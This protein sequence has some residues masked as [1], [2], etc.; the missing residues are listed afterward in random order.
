MAEYHHEQVAY[1]NDQTVGLHAIIA[2]HSTVLGPSLGGCR[3]YHYA[4]EQDALADV[5]RLSHAMTYKAAAA[6]VAFGGGKSV[7][8]ADETTVKSEQIFRSFGRFVGSL[9]GRY[10]ASE[11]VGTSMADLE[12]AR[13]ETIHVARDYDCPD[14]DMNYLTA[15]GTY[16]GMRAAA[17]RVFGSPSLAGRTVAV[18]GLGHVGW[19]LCELLHAAGADLIVTDLRADI[20][21]RARAKW[22]ARAVAVDEILATPCD[23]LAPCAMGGVLDD[24]SIPGLACAIVAGSAN[25]V[26]AAPEHGRALHER[27]VLL[28][29]DYVINGGGLIAEACRLEGLD[30]AAARERVLRVYDNVAQ[31]LDLAD[32]EQIAPSDAADRFAEQR[33]A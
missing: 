17:T 28:A 20:C 19:P 3:M 5:L 13:R 1:W 8:L 29:P 7:I 15:L 27:G 21:D 24:A 12:W 22:G 30:F 4:C 18:Q 14:G 11:D 6:G 10:T 9:G 33:L 31:V 32:S 2:I 16:E 23:V 26:L 25:N